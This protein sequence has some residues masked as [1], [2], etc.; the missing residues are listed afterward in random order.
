[1][2]LIRKQSKKLRVGCAEGFGSTQSRVRT[3]ANL[4]ENVLTV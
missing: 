2:V 1:M 3:N 4:F